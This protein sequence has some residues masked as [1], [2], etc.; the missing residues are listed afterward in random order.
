LIRS[1]PVLRLEHF[2]ETFR[3]RLLLIDAASLDA[4]AR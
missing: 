4:G 2:S 3:D 1:G